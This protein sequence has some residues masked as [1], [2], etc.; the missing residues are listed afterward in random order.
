MKIQRVTT[1]AKKLWRKGRVLVAG[2]AAS[3]V[4]MV[5]SGAA[6]AQTTLASLG[7][8]AETEIEGLVSQIIP[9]GIAIIGVAVAI[10]AVAVILR[11]TKKA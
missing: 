10:A 2:A 3:A 5:Y 6:Y 11:L 8:D 4:P 1:G 9:I 7:T